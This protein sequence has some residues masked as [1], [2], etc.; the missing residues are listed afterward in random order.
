MTI[1][2]ILIN[3]KNISPL[4][5][6]IILSFIVK[7]PKEFLYTYPE[8]KLTINQIKKFKNLVIRR[9]KG[10]PV[11]YLTNHKEFYGLDFYINKNILIPRPE[12]ETLI[13]EIIKNEKNK[14]LIIT[15]IGTGS[16]CIAITL[17]KF[18][19]KAKIYATDICKKALSVASKNAKIHNVKINFIQGNLLEPLKNKKIDIV[20][21]NLPYGWK[22]WK[23]NSST[24]TSG[25]KFEPQKALFTKEGG[26]F[27]YLQLFSQLAKRKQKPKSIYGEFDPRQK[28][29]LQKIIK[30]YLPEYKVKIK[31]DLA[32]RDRIFI[33][34]I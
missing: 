3:T 15:D 22:E 2:Q 33:A 28:K 24:E 7:K 20:V 4:D 13:E 8:Y 16:G 27:L 30:K 34:N 17:A 23:N 29:D 32:G 31:K 6:E 26:L 5:A 12:T 19:P 11:A 18:L 14:K 21:A 1:K 25:L 10:E 9:S